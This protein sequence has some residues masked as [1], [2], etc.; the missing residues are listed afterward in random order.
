[1][2]LLQKLTQYLQASEMIQAAFI[3]GS[4]ARSDCPADQYSDIDIIVIT[5]APQQYFNSDDWLATI[6]VSC[7]SVIEDSFLGG[8]ARRI[9]FDC[10]TDLDFLVF[11]KELV[12]NIS[13]GKLDWLLTRGYVV[14]KDEL[15]IAEILKQ[16]RCRANQPAESFFR[17]D[18]FTNIVQNFWF[19][20]VWAAKKMA[21][22]ELWT[23]KYCL[24]VYMKRHV[25]TL[26][27]QNARLSGCKDAWYSGRFIE[28]WADPCILNS[29]AA[30]F[31]HYDVQDMA[32]ALL[33]TMGFFR[34]MA[35]KLPFDYPKQAEQFAYRRVKAIINLEEI[36]DV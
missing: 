7:I 26:I 31:A 30:A 36:Q 15:G 29:L 10:G 33:A 9:L 24:D 27:E 4:Q 14:I 2:T 6:G 13:A 5:T 34:D 20:A 3:V 25:L 35:T 12:A 22:G 23:A 18:A 32:R 21:R 19:H 16:A 17:Q 8:K 28:R 11:A 1:V